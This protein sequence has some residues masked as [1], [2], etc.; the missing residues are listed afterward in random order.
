MFKDIIRGL[1]AYWDAVLL[2]G[3]QGWWKFALVPGL[4]SLAFGSIVLFLAWTLSDNIGRL[5]MGWLADYF[6]KKYVML[7]IYFLIATAI[8][9]LFF[10]S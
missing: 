1:R 2:L 8:P 5:L 9:L 10:A 3:R 7:I 4:I 6:A